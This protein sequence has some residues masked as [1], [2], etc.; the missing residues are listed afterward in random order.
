MRNLLSELSHLRQSWRIAMAS[1]RGCSTCAGRID[2]IQSRNDLL[3]YLS[4]YNGR[5]TFCTLMAS[6]VEVFL[7]RIPLMEG[8]YEKFPQSSGVE[9][10]R[11]IKLFF[12]LKLTATS[13]L[14]LLLGPA[15]PTLHLGRRQR[16]KIRRLG[17]SISWEQD[18]HI[19]T[20]D[21]LL[22]RNPTES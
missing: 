7:C 19:A 3:G 17:V 13:E 1:R 11:V 20:Q 10:G 12:I 4:N 9:K 8:S 2:M 14:G 18:T 16:A 6:K 5:R 22:Y 15:G 21:R